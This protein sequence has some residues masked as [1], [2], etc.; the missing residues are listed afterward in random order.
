MGLIVPRDGCA[1]GREGAANLFDCLDVVGMARAHALH[2]LVA[3]LNESSDADVHL[4][5]DPPPPC[6]SFEDNLNLG[7]IKGTAIRR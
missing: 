6:R 1:E 4:F 2:A 7:G 5:L 3:R